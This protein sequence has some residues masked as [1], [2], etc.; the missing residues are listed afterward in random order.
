MIKFCGQEKCI[1]DSNGRIKLSACVLRDFQECNK[2][3][4]ILHCLVEG[5]LAVYP[6]S[7]WQQMR[8]KDE[9]KET[10][11]ANSVVFRR[12][13]RRFGS[14]SQSVSISNQGRITIPISYREH[15]SLT[16]GSEVMVVGCEIGVEIWNCERWFDEMKLIHQHILDKNKNEMDADLTREELL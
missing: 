14:F 2:E 6:P 4:V 15:A 1:I 13:L 5:A 9:S 7:V 10:N 11:A 8:G 3:I 12:S 16:P